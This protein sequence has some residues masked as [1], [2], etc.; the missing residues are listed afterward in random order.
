MVFDASGCNCIVVRRCL[1]S[2]RGC[3][4]PQIAARFG[5]LKDLSRADVARLMEDAQDVCNMLWLGDHD[6]EDG[7]G[8]A[9]ATGS[10]PGDLYPEGRMTHLLTLIGRQLVA[11]W[12]DQLHRSH[13][14]TAV[15]MALPNGA[16]VMGL[17][18]D[19][20]PE[21]KTSMTAALKVVTQ[22]ESAVAEMMRTWPRWAG[23]KYVDAAV[24]PFR[25]RLRAIF[26]V[27]TLQNEV[28]SVLTQA[29]QRRRMTA[30]FQA[31]FDVY[32]ASFS[33]AAGGVTAAS[34]NPLFLCSAVYED[35]W[36][37]AVMGF[38]KV[39]EPLELQLSAILRRRLFSLSERPELLLA[40]FRKFPELLC[41][42]RIAEDLT[43]ERENLLG[44]MVYI[45][46]FCRCFFSFFLI[47]IF[48]FQYIFTARNFC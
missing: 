31:P 21:V 23:G 19:S 36:Q 20:Y 5:A 4:I 38:Q 41:Q 14:V 8:A 25:A 22:W 47:Y 24:S 10:K 12:T 1:W 6:D 15:G 42:K 18:L 30:A 16:G 17:L 11:Y 9:V 3:V 33:L 26:K 2:C 34:L 39:M 44:Q 48:Y 7:G 28:H 27:R 40:E 35:K 37:A 43:A 13:G 29:D 46:N 45:N 32:F